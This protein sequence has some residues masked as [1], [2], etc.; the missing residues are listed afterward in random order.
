MT[1]TSAPASVTADTENVKLE[2]NGEKEVGAEVK[3]LVPMASPSNAIQWESDNESVVSVEASS[4]DGTRAVLTGN[5]IGAAAVTAS[6]TETIN[7]KEYTVSDSNDIASVVQS[8]VSECDVLYI[9][10][11]NTMAGNTESINNIALPAGVPIIAGEEGICSGCGVATLSISYYDLGAKAAEMAYDILVNGKK[12]AEMPIEYLTD[13]LVPK[14]NAD[15][16]EA[17]GV[18]I[19]EGMEPVA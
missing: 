13:G 19:P 17:L 3:L 5:D 11:D 14:Y 8:A 10:T 18:T 15:I 16:A 9:P 7:G 2:V 6:Y 12:P 4:E 1:V